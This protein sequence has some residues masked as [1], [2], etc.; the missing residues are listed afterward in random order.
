MIRSAL[1]LITASESWE[2]PV[3]STSIPSCGIP[4][5]HGCATSGTLGAV[6]A[7]LGPPAESGAEEPVKELGATTEQAAT[8]DATHRVAASLT[9]TR[10]NTRGRPWNTLLIGPRNHYV[11]EARRWLLRCQTAR[12]WSAGDGTQGCRPICCI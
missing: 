1:A 9:N 6:D 4:G 10:T 3:Q 7:G 2:F 5:C 12:A 11:A 8:I